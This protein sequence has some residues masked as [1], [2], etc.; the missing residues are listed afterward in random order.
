MRLKFEDKHWSEVPRE[1]FKAWGKFERL[2]VNLVQNKLRNQHEFWTMFSISNARKLSK[3]YI[4]TSIDRRKHKLYAK[5]LVVY[6]RTY[7]KII[8]QFRKGELF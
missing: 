2:F 7:L 3:G 4:A 6:L 8:N 5:A 1:H